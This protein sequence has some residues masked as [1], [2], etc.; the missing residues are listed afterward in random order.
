MV[1]VMTFLI[2]IEHSHRYLELCKWS[3]Y[4]GWKS[5]ADI[6]GVVCL[7]YKLTWE[8]N[9]HIVKTVMT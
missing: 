2:H 1:K 7:S 9:L 3:N 4:Q 6:I 8:V 5:L